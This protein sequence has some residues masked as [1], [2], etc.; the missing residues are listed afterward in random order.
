MNKFLLSLIA[1]LAFSGSYV[2]SF[3]FD[4]ER[5]EKLEINI[6]EVQ[7]KAKQGDAVSQ[8]ILGYC[9]YRG[10]GISKNKSEAINWIRKS[11]NQDYSEAIATLGY[12]YYV[13]V[14]DYIKPD[15][16]EAKRLLKRA[17]DKGSG[18][19]GVLLLIIQLEEDKERDGGIH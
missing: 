11:A 15:K 3:D 18:R 6:A 8:Y 13:G 16:A 2:Y 12:F 19:A 10:N 5:L 9:L 14:K 17:E 1:F 7:K 4:Y